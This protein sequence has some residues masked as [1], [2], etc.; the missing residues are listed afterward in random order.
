MSIKIEDREVPRGEKVKGFIKVGETPSHDVTIPYIIIR[1]DVDGPVLCVLGGVHALEYASI[2][3]VIRVIDEV[4]PEDLSGT[5]IAIPVVNMEGFDDRAAFINPIDYVN[6]NRVFPGDPEGTMSRRVANALFENFVSKAD[7]LIDSHGGDLT[8][9]ISRFVIIGKTD[10]GTIRQKMVDMASCYDA[11]YIRVTDIKGSTK[12]ALDLY[13]IP[14]ITPE[15]GT[16]YPV[17]EEET[18]FH[19]KGI[20]NVMRYM[21]LLDGE[22]E[23]RELAVDPEQVKLYAERGGIWLQDVD[24]GQPVKEGDALGEVINVF[25][26]TLQTVKAPFNGVANNSRTSSVVNSGDTLLYVV[27]V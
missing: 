14:C 6:Q 27:K 7:A 21:G 26:D 2:R 12:E 22:P 9:D 19:R 5:L 10:D 24:A 16:P 18:E 23:I 15:S 1:G 17:R 4:E 25:G 8:E 13:G 20:L 11:H 3:G